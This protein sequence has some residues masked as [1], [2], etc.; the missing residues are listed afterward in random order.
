MKT[1][2]QVHGVWTYEV[3]KE[4]NALLGIF[5]RKKPIW[6]MHSQFQFNI[7][8]IIIWKEKL[9]KSSLGKIKGMKNQ[10]GLDRAK[11]IAFLSLVSALHS[12]IHTAA[13]VRMAI[14]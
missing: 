13:A 1:V 5:W 11:S 3:Q 4:V 6:Y 12:C 2:A 9:M 7:I 14:N 8:I 10:K